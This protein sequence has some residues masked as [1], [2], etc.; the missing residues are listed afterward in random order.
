MSATL[1]ARGVVNKRWG[2]ITPL[3]LSGPTLTENLSVY[4]LGH[5]F[6]EVPLEDPS[7]PPMYFV[8]DFL[9]DQSQSTGGGAFMESPIQFDLTLSQGYAYQIAAPSGKRFHVNP[10]ANVTASFSAWLGRQQIA[11]SLSG[12]F[13]PMLAQVSFENL[14]GTSPTLTYST[15]SLTHADNSALLFEVEGETTSSLKFDS[16]ILSAKFT[17]AI[18][19]G[20]K[21]YRPLSYAV[22]FGTK[23]IYPASETF[24]L[25]SYQTKNSV[26]P[27]PFVT[28]V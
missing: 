24:V 22:P 25:F 5:V 13:D 20:A 18:D 6:G 15:F 7:R 16:L 12:F 26:D 27:G 14:V 4:G 8:S 9:V 1:K 21:W 3:P 23:D 10:P 2:H 19:P 17:R 28:I 11:S